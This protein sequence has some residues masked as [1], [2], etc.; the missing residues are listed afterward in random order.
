MVERTDNALGTAFLGLTVGCA[1]CHDHKYDP[2]RQTRLLLARRVLQQHRRAGLI[3]AGLQRH[4]GRSDAAVARCCDGTKIAAAGAAIA[5]R[6]AE[7]SARRAAARDEA[8]RPAPSSPPDRRRA[9]RASPLVDLHGAR[10]TLRV[11]VRAPGDAGRPAGPR[12]PRIPPPASSSSGA[13][14]SPGRRLRRTKRRRSAGNARR[15]LGCSA[16]PATTTRIA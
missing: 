7:P 4:S 9:S 16:C 5:E 14:R 10:R 15:S 1:R 13:T 6:E 3:R 12:P 8:A 2:I 11:R